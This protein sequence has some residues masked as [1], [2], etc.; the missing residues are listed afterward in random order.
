MLYAEI[1]EFDPTEDP[2]STMDVEVFHYEGPFSK[3]EFLGHAEINFL[4]QTPSQLADFRLPLIGKSTQAH[5]SELHLGVSLTNTRHGDA[6]PKYL[7]HV[8][9]EVGLKVLILL[10]NTHFGSSRFM[11]VFFLLDRGRCLSIGA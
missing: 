6:L 9:R 3:A 8:E 5:G 11:F 4:K 2:P 10:N 7:E 1:F